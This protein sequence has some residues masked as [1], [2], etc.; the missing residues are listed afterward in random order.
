MRIAP[1][2]AL[3][4]Q[5][6]TLSPS[7]RARRQ[8][9]GRGRCSRCRGVLLAVGAF[10]GLDTGTAMLAAR[11]RLHRAVRRAWRCSPAA[12]C[13]PL[14]ALRRRAG[15]AARPR[16]PPRARATP[17]RNPQRTA[18]T[19]AALMIGLALVTLVATLGQGLRVVGP[20]GARGRRHAPT[21][22]SRPRTASTRSRPRSARPSPRRPGRR[23]C[24]RS[25]TTRRRR[26]A[27]ASPSTACRR[28]TATVVRIRGDVPPALPR[29]GEALVEKKLRRQARPRGRRHV[30]R[31]DRRATSRSS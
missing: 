26:S 4:E 31:D 19:A 21:T 12:S 30:R 6:A 5:A 18:S 15:D 7:P 24:T 2:A 1:V 27:R 22:S 11:R 16:R 23:R 9:D 3:Q 8:V 25:A 13:G 29:P 10:A 17:T 20:Q 14:A 28:T